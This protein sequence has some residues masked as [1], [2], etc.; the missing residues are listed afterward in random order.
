MQDFVTN[1]MEEFGYWGLF[2]LMVLENVFPPIPSEI[3][4]PFSGF[5]TV[6][7]SLTITGVILA[8]TFGSV[9]G[10]LILYSIGYMVNI[11]K[12][13]KSIDKWGHI[14]RITTQDLQKA[15][16]WFARFGYW[17]ILF[18]RMIPLIRS[19]ISVP[20][21]M[22]KMYLYL[23]LLFTTIGTIIWNTILIMMGATLG[24][25]WDKILQW[26]E[27]YSSFAYLLIFI[28][29]VVFVILFYK[30]KRKG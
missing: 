11:T 6:S 18:G 19:L 29:L 1:I 10:A 8:S 23:F 24:E 28:G 30:G 12:L 25:N 16:T 5:M 17:T 22:A 3:V 9:V 7:S 26:M 13:E 21:G 27:T 14:L 15:N 4:L 20:A 2:L